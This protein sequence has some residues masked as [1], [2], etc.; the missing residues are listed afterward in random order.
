MRLQ[1]ASLVVAFSLVAGLTTVT[2]GLA[3]SAAYADDVAALPLSGYAHL[4][5]DPA[6]QH[7][8]VSQG[9]GSA[10]IVVTDLSGTPVTTVAG[11]Q[12]ATGLALSPDGGTLYAA[13]ADGGA[14]AAIDTATL[15]ETARWSTGAGSSPVSVAVAGGR[16]WYG[17]TA[18]GKGG[19]GSVDPSAPAPAAIPQPA[20]SQWTTAP[21]LAAGGDVLAAEEPQ[22]SLSHVATFNVASG[23]AS[24]KADT[25]VYGGTATGLAVTGDGTRVLL[26]A[27]QQLAL[28]A[29][30]STDLAAA[31]PAAYFT[32]GSG[33]A[34][35]SV[36]VDTDGTVAVAGTSGVYLY[37]G[38]NTLAENHLTL[39]SGTLAP[40]GLE[41]GADGTTLY[42]V[43]KDSS[44]AHSLNV[45]DAPKLTDTELALRHPQYA[46]P[47]ERYTVSGSLSTRGF[48]PAGAALKVTRDGTA[49]PG[50]TL[51]ADGTFTFTDLRQDEGTYA[52]QVA[53]A[54]DATHRPATAS[55]SVNVAKLPTDVVGTDITSANP[56]SVVLT[57]RLMAQ[58]GL[59]T[60]PQGTTVQVARRDEAT[61]QTV[62]LGS[63][64]VDPATLQFTVTDAPGAAGSFMYVFAYAGDATHQPSE[65]AMSIMV[66]P[67]APTLTLNAPATAVRGAALSFGGKLG[68]GPYAAGRTVT[69][70]R[71]D[72]AHSTPVT[73]TTPVAADGTITVKDTPDIGGANTYTVTYPGDASHKAATA[74]ATVQVSRAATALTVAGNA[75]SYAYGATAT[76]TAHLGTTYNGRTVSIYATP[77]GGTKT[78]LTTGTVDTYGN[79]RTTYKITR[80]TTFTASFAGDY[81]YAPATAARAVNGYVKIA[82]ALGGYYTSTTYSGITYRVFHKTVKPTVTATVTPNKAGQ[83]ERFQVQ[84][85]YSGAWHTL[86]TSGCYALSS[87]SSAKAQ[88]SLTNA[89]NQKFRVRPTYERSTKD[90][91]NVSTWGGWLYFVVRT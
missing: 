29:Y 44:G 53:Y 40:D 65:S 41:W 2:A 16:V 47:T 21:L 46:V 71:K 73:W 15:T 32:G 80:N 51:G 43:T 26:A 60:F 56:G 14:I 66:A 86:T 30:R 11:E 8:F 25:L 68:D 69:V 78:L 50:T 74:L 13:L 45:L 82:T 79:L 3:G 37:A 12:G 63:V 62:P 23:T 91:S 58:L 34:P 48:L 55:L 59:G 38:T 27:P 54:G 64:P 28:R 84:Q 31:D 39:P 17:Y 36:A 4:V 61:Q 57:G 42:A 49:L 88:L 6:H 35:G 24:V 18:D 76:V 89:L 87:T 67:Y 19:I 10:G 52:Y 75:S 20:L 81:R 9:V 33:S 7:V 70:S 5:V 1:Q 22:G 72:A 85:Y 83:C 77:Y 90:L